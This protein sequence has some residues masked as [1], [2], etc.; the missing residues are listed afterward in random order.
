MRLGVVVVVGAV[1]AGVMGADVADRAVGAVGVVAAAGH[2]HRRGVTAARRQLGDLG[3]D[4]LADGLVAELADV[5]PWWPP[6]YS[7][8]NVR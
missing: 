3:V 2:R 1:R 4:V 6:R 7:P 8:K 5:G